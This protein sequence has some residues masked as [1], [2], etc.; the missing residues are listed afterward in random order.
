M[1]AEAFEKEN[2][3]KHILNTDDRIFKLIRDDHIDKSVKMLTRELK[4]VKERDNTNLNQLEPEQ[5]KKFVGM[6]PQHKLGKGASF[7]LVFDYQLPN[8]LLYR[9]VGIKLL[10]FSDDICFSETNFNGT[11]RVD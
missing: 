5:M 2:D 4:T 8:M 1:P 11:Y 9:W 10:R 7:L 6:L 3:L